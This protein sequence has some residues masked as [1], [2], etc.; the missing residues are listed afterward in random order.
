MLGVLLL[1]PL[2]PLAAHAAL[3]ELTSPSPVITVGQTVVVDLALTATSSVNALEIWL[4]FDHHGLQLTEVERENSIV[5]L[6]AEEPQVDNSAGLMTFTGGM[7]NPGYQGEH[8]HLTRLTFRAKTVGSFAIRYLPRSTVLLNDGAGT[9]D[10]LVLQTVQVLGRGTPPGD[11]TRWQW[12][13]LLLL[14]VALFLYYLRRRYQGRLLS[15]GGVSAGS[16]LPQPSFFMLHPE[17]RCAC[18]AL[19]AVALLVCLVITPW[20]SL[21]PKSQMGAVG[22]SASVLAN[23]VNTLVVQLRAKETQLVQQEQRLHDEQRTFAMS[24]QTERIRGWV[25]EAL[26]VV[27]VLLSLIHLYHDRRRLRISSPATA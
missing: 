6:W 17:M 11:E 5:K 21:A 2:G 4:G 3:L 26:L 1:A 9:P 19:G 18:V 24:T 14:L 10:T 25:A 22:T 7:P 27:L 20:S 23:P 8:G 16:A 12:P 15:N 13:G